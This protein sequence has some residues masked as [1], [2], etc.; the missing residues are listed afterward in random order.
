MAYT[1]TAF[2]LCI[3]YMFNQSRIWGDCFPQGGG[4]KSRSISWS[5]CCKTHA[6]SRFWGQRWNSPIGNGC[7]GSR[8]LCWCPFGGGSE[9]VGFGNPNARKPQC[10][11]G[12]VDLLCSTAARGFLQSHERLHDWHML[13]CWQIVSHTA[14]KHRQRMAVRAIMGH[15]SISSV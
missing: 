14:K 4:G 11:A 3:P 15:P 5:W 6:R 12:P 7:H 2:F 8:C 10:A 1:P 13:A 9:H